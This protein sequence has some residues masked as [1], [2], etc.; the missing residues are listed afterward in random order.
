M[1]QLAIIT[2]RLDA[3]AANTRQLMQRDA[4]RDHLAPIA[5]DRP[6]LPPAPPL[7]LPMFPHGPPRHPSVTAPHAGLAAR[8]GRRPAIDLVVVNRAASETSDFDRDAINMSMKM[9]VHVMGPNTEFRHWK[10]KFLDFLSVKA[11]YLIPQLAL[12]E[13]GEYLDENA[14]TLC[15]CTSPP[16]CWRQ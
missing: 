8:G 4:L 7:A 9:N 12:R 16:R 5:V 15:V 3:Q 13:S 14:Q 11:T 10:N 2:S 6:F 1:E